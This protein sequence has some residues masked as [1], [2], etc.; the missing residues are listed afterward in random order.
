MDIC[1]YIHTYTYR[2]TYKYTY[3]TNENYCFFLD[4]SP[5]CISFADVKEI[6]NNFKKTNIYIYNSL[7]RSICNFCI[8][9]FHFLMQIFTTY[10]FSSSLIHS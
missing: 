10:Y 5:F 8:D 7:N 9:N 6:Y 3:I 4:Y 2:Y 1:S